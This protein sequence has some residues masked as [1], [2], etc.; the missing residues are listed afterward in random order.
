MHKLLKGVLFLAALLF[1]HDILAHAL[2]ENYVFL[3]F[4]ENSIDGRFEFNDEDLKTKIGVDLKLAAEQGSESVAAEEQR[5]RDYIEAHFSIAP[6]NGDPY[7]LEF[8]DQVPSDP[9]SGWAQF[10]FRADTGPLPDQLTIRHNM[11][12]EGDRMHRGLILVNYNAKTN[13][14]YPDEYT[15][16]VFSSSNK[17][18]TL[19][20]YDIPSLITL[21][22]MVWMGVLHIWIG[23]DHILF[24]VALILPVVL[25]R[26]DNS[27]KPIPRFRTALWNLLKIVTVFTIA[28]SITLLL[29]ALDIVTVPSR[30]VESMIALSI[31]LVAVNNLTATV[32]YGS[33]LVILV[34][35]L[36]HGLGFATVMGRLPFRMNQL[37]ENVVAFNVGIELG[38]IA[39]VGI[40][41][42]IL[43][44]LRTNAGYVPI[45]LRG[46]STVLIV[47]SGIWFVQRALGF[48]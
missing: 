12:F 1:G 48:G 31:L 28:H 41:F 25:L 46:G 15:A 2:G 21:G 7:R 38:Q 39:I 17:E 6:E 35:G 23:I 13:T 44:V 36:F 10:H 14:K 16:L 24:L 34:L 3:N 43:Y 22:G 47:V 4:R 11:G 33:L 29:A 27:W 45:V 9:P 30:F 19:D 20:L 32:R 8:V 40:L 5:V 42:P 26:D 37:L 18:Q